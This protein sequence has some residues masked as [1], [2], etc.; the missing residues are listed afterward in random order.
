[1]IRVCLFDGSDLSVGGT[2]LISLPIPSGAVL[3]IDIHNETPGAEDPIFEQFGCHSLCIQDARRERH[4]PKTEHFKDQS[5][6]LL[7]TLADVSEGLSFQTQQVAFFIG[8]NFLITRHDQTC[9]V[10]D[11]WWNFGDVEGAMAKGSWVLFAAITN[12]MGLAYI[13]MLLEFEPTLSE[14]EDSLMDAPG[15]ELLRQLI[16]CKTSLRKLKRMHSYHDSAY[17][18]LL[19]HFDADNLIFAESRHAVTD[20]Y[21][22]FERLHSLSSL[23]YDLAGDLIDGHISLTSHKLKDTMRIL[24]VVTTIFVPLGFLAGLYGMNFD[25]MPELHQPN[26]YFILVGLM[27]TIAV[28]LVAL[29]KRNKWL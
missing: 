19:Q 24:T 6:V 8:D 14:F 26:G 16:A 21:E 27:A 12:S 3:W 17:E 7:R 23:Y 2:E 5:F 1:M 20:V 28:G 4:P 15:D 10:I 13:D 11:N 22:K 25:N 9:E 29:F 18:E